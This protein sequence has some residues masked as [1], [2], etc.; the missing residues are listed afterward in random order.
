MAICITCQ[1]NVLERLRQRQ[2]LKRNRGKQKIDYQ[3]QWWQ[4]NRNC[5]VSWSRF[6][7][8][9]YFRPKRSSFLEYKRSRHT[10][11]RIYERGLLSP[12][13]K[14]NLLSKHKP[15]IWDQQR[16]TGP[17]PLALLFCHWPELAKLKR[18]RE[19]C[20]TLAVIVISR[21]GT[22]LRANWIR[23]LSYNAKQ[24]Q[25]Q[26]VEMLLLLLLLSRVA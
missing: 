2:Q 14:K 3:S 26:L 15:L 7:L 5:G 23:E 19:S 1:Q 18:K 22:L 9:L 6:S 11:T 24:A 20:L 17:R 10:Y 4:V 21:S 12:E 13:K 16:P 8:C 25:Q